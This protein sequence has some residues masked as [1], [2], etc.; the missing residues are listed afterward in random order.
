MHVLIAPDALGS[1]LGASDTGAALAAGWSRGAPHDSVEV[2]PLS[3]GGRGL[4]A[5]V[6][7]A[8][9]VPPG[10][11]GVLLVPGTRGSTTAYIDSHRYVDLAR[12]SFD[13]AQSIERALDAGAGRVVV[14]LPGPQESSGVPDA[15]AGLLTALGALAPGVPG[16]G[17][18]LLVARLGAT[19]TADLDGLA[20]VRERLRGIDLVGAAATDVPLLGLHGASAAAAAAGVLDSARAHDLERAIGHFA[21]QVR[22]VVV[23]V[24]D[25]R[26]PLG[27]VGPGAAEVHPP[28]AGRALTSG[29]G[30]GAGGGL[31]FALCAL[32]G[33]VV[34]GAGLVAAAVGLRARAEGADLVLTACGDLDGATFHGSPAEA[35]VR[36]AGE[37]GVP[38]VAVAGTSLMSRRER[39]AAGLNGVV[40]V[41]E[42]A[43]GA[44]APGRARDELERVAERLARTWSPARAHGPGVLGHS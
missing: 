44:E 42:G 29:A 11:D 12:S 36:A 24:G 15:G 33:R 39:A 41:D 13:L 5:L 14:G 19:A 35:A 3:A 2:C 8:A 20:G 6:A 9:G 27:L 23:R 25:V 21:H 37:W 40:T 16:G 18:D 38:S 26:R 7:A 32:G 43:S 31:G 1:A 4:V 30:T 17:T 10:D 22:E 34:D 28:G